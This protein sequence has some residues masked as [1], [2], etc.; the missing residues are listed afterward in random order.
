MFA[1]VKNE[2]KRVLKVFMNKENAVNELS[3]YNTCSIVETGM[4]FRVT[5]D[6][7]NDPQ[8]RDDDFAVRFASPVYYATEAAA[9]AGIDGYHFIEALELTAENC[10]DYVR[11][12]PTEDEMFAFLNI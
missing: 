11:P 12:I 5:W 6:V 1:I 10:S 2:D 8:Y 3:E 9:K 4:I 7:H